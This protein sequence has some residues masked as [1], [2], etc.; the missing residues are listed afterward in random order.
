MQ[1]MT[2]EEIPSGTNLILARP[3]ILGSGVK[4]FNS[5]V[6]ITDTVVAALK[7]LGFNEIWTIDEN[8]Y[9]PQVINEAGPQETQKEKFQRIKSDLSNSI[10]DIMTEQDPQRAILRIKSMN[11]NSVLMQ[12]G[13]LTEIIPDRPASQL[14]DL[15]KF[16]E[17]II[18]V[19]RLE[20]FISTCR[21]LIEKDFTPSSISKVRLN[22]LDSRSE[23]T[24]LFNHMATC[25]LYFLATMMRINADLKAKGAVGTE[26]RFAKGV[27]QDKK[28]LF[29]FSDEEIL[30][31]A[32]GAFTHD[33]GYL[34]DT[35]PGILF[36]DGVISR[37]EHEILKK[38]VEVSMNI[39]NYHMF[40]ESRPLARHTIENHHE[41]LDGSG[42]PKQRTNFHIFSRVLGIIDVFD[43]MV[44]DRPWR[45]KFARS[46]VLEWLYEKSRQTL[47]S[48]GEV[49]YSLFD[50][51]ALVAFEQILQLYENDEVVDIYHV[52]AGTPVFKAKVKDQNPGR[53]DRPIVELISC[54]TDETKCVEGKEVNMLNIKDLYVGESTSF[55]NK[56]IN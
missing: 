39:L 41:R 29:F 9:I 13:A 54:Y 6:K 50:R 44:T 11:K 53:P 46:K 55:E 27:R 40:F 16:S 26:L 33:I 32:A 31:G 14:R 34:H 24:Y 35:M 45:K 21:D 3:V 10:A 56:P 4:G 7:R 8:E 42:Y 22:L 20:Q 48:S 19:A 51:E 47:S 36:K 28:Q 25:G 17:T 38:H 18:P 49:N 43:S 30:S 1:K 23:S 15:K 52:K 2:L 37:E 12:K 5:G